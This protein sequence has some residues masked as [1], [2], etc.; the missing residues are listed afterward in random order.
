MGECVRMI[1]SQERW[2]SELVPAAFFLVDGPI[3]ANM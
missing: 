1:D 3:A 2:P